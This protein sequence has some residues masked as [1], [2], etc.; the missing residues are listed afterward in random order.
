MKARKLGYDVAYERRP[1]VHLLHVSQ[2][3]MLGY[4]GWKGYG[5]PRLVK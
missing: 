4:F 5:R 1:S 2:C 3:E